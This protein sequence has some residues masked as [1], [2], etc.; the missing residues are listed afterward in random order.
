MRYLLTV[1]YDGKNF[2]GWQRQ[3]DGSAIQNYV[4]NAL[5][6][7]LK[8]DVETV[9]SG[10]TDAGVSA[11]A[12][13]VHFDF[14]GEINKHKFLHSMN[15]IL[16]DEIKVLDIEKTEIHAQHSAKR[17][18]YLY[19]MYLSKVTL[20]LMSNRLRVDENIDLKAMKK[21]L[22]YL[23][24]EHDFKG[25][26]CRGSEREST[27]RKIFDIKLKRKG[28]KLNLFVTGNGFLYKMV[29]NIAGTMLEVG[30]HKL[31]LKNLK[32]TLFTSFQ[33]KQTAKP[34]FLF[35]YNVV[36]K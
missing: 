12:Q 22:S 30:K 5:K 25:F 35:L 31:E 13:P 21:F 11:Y 33:A 1:S 32:P 3:K 16:P 23:K 2:N 6:L 18:T 27:V 29:R 36:Y 28:N 20:P 10:R 24:G 34:E 8:T 9:A 19:K 4:E 26:Q 15:G 17:K 14:D 7:V